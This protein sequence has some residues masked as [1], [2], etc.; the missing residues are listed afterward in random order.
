MISYNMS[1]QDRLVAVTPEEV[2]HRRAQ[3]FDAL[4]RAQGG[5]AEG[6]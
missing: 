5:P 6:T 4:A 2:A 3:Y 1:D